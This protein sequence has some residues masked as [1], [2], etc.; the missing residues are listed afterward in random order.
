MSSLG[1]LTSGRH[2]GSSGPGLS[3]H[4]EGTV[5]VAWCC[6]TV[7]GVRV[8][9]WAQFMLLDTEAVGKLQQGTDLRRGPPGLCQNRPVCKMEPETRLR[10]VG[11]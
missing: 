6:R 1:T 2:R 9:T 8:E 3:R 5:L 7:M 4:S 11:G 10:D